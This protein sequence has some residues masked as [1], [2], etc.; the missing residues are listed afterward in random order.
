MSKEN[1]K[2]EVKIDK[3]NLDEECVRNA[4]YFDDWAIKEADALNERDDLKAKIET[5]K[6]KV[7][8]K[9]R[10]ME[11]DD[12]CDL[13]D[14]NIPKITE[15][16]MKALVETHS[17]V[18]ELKEDFFKVKNNARTYGVARQSFEQKKSMLE[19][20]AKLHGQGYFSRIE[21]KEY[22]EQTTKKR[23]RKIE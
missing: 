8:L 3:H 14:L 21:G 2:E 10:S 5:M 18:E 19:A 9:L 17:E 12:I 4:S 15:N 13:Y 6:S 7:E 1:W 16:T 20:L 23:R 11:L 22:R